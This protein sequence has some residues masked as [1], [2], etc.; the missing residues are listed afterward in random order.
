MIRAEE[1][2][3]HTD[4][5]PP[6]VDATWEQNLEWVKAEETKGRL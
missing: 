1:Q 6:A 5:K 4:K 2:R 3:G